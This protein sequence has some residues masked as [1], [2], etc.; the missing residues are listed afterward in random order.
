MTPDQKDLLKRFY[1]AL[2]EVPLLEHRQALYVNRAEGDVSHDPVVRLQDYIDMS[3]APNSTYL[4]RGLRGSGKTTE[5]LRLV[6]E[7]NE[8]GAVAAY[9]CDASL[10]LNLNDPKLS[11]PDLVMTALAGLSDAVRKR[12][13]NDPIKSSIWER[14]KKLANSEV[15]LKPKFKASA[16]VPGAE[17]EIEATLLEN[18]AF[19]DKLNAFA[20]ASSEFYKEAD[21]FA[22]ELAQTIHAKTQCEKIVLVVDSLERLTAARGQE[23]LLFGSLKA[24]YFDFPARLQLPGISV[25]Y[26]APPYLCTVLPNVDAGF[27]QAFSLSNFMVMQRPTVA[28]TALR[29]NA[30]GIAQMVDI[31]ARRFPD[32][33]QVLTLDALEELAWNSG[34]NA[35]V[36]CRLARE[37]A[38]NARL[39]DDALPVGKDAPALKQALAEEIEP[40]KS[41]TKQDW[42]WLEH[43]RQD[44]DCAAQHIGDLESDL[45]GLIRLFDHSLVLNYQNGEEWYQVPPL[46]RAH[47]GLG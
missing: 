1:Q 41:L 46:V 10:Y 29:R 20:L 13:G 5:L 23:K 18:P 24:V 30:P 38:F 37:T 17:F 21:A 14:M 32:W 22:E 7:L 40:L 2:Y 45:P 47:G 34:G 11:L 28:D 8:G 16:G 25:V 36:F 4:F 31:V 6:H 35:R 43:V 26:S 19:K 3:P 44:S 42:A 12:H 39:R 9:Y 27:A 15:A 33:Q